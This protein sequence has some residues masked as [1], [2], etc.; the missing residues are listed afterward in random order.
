M[1]LL[2]MTV[3]PVLVARSLPARATAPTAATLLIA[4]SAM[5][6][7][8]APSEPMLSCALLAASGLLFSLWVRFK[9]SASVQVKHRPG[10]MLLDVCANW[11]ISLFALL[12][13]LSSG[14]LARFQ[15][16]AICGNADA[17]TL[18]HVALAMAA[19]IALGVIADKTQHRRAL[20]ALYLVRA[21][22]LAVLTTSV[23]ITL[24]PL[25][26]QVLL[27]LDY[28]TIPTLMRLT[29]KNSGGIVAG[30]PGAAHH[31]GMLAGATLSTTPYFFNNG[32][33]ALFVFSV[34]LN[35][36]CALAL[37]P[38]SPFKAVR[39]FKRINPLALR[40]EA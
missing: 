26:A 6:A 10:E 9:R 1:A 38:Y 17:N 27:V 32:F 35:L 29:E 31:V 21:S 4:M 28:L 37:T 33:I 25:A 39:L 7:A 23:S 3:T 36:G 2:L 40:P 5:K 15:L 13:G 34:L 24:A 12:A 16:F 11:R 20:V 8:P 30:C 14:T 22:L 19:V 18:S